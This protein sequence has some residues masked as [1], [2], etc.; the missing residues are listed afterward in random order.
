MFLLFL[1]V[2]VGLPV[3]EIYVI[4]LVGEAIGLLWTVVLLIASSMIG[5]RLVRSQGRAVLRN[6]QSAIA[7]GRP[8]AREALDGAL[9][10][11]GGALLI[12]PGFITDVIGAI[13]LIP[14][15]RAIVR[16]LIVRHY[17]G[18]L[19]GYVTRTGPGQGHPGQ[20]PDIDGT[21]VDIDAGELPR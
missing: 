3:L 21:A 18:R 5:V 15:T 13:L 20:P 6:F 7:A 1:A 4:V 17:S 16:L 2:L 9:V 14:P 12:A 19:I 8:P 11:V 10:F